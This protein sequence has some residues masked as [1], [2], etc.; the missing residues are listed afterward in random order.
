V[1]RF[2]LLVVSNSKKFTDNFLINFAK[3][4]NMKIRIAVTFL[5]IGL[6]VG[7]FAQWGRIHHN[8]ERN[9]RKHFEKEGEAIGEKHAT[10]AANE[11]IESANDGIDKWEE[12]EEEQFADEKVFIDTNFIEYTDIQWQRL[13]FVSGKNVVF[14][15]KPFNYEKDEKEPSNWFLKNKSKGEVQ[16]SSLD[17][18]KVIIVSADGYL[19]PKIENA[20]KDYLP[21]NFTLEFDFMMPVIPFSKPF[22][23]YFY[24]KDKQKS[25]GSAPIKINQNVVTFKDSTGYYPVMANDENGMSNWYHLSVSYNKGFLKIYLNERLMVTYNEEINPTGITIDYYAIAPIFYKNLL[26]ASDQEP[27]IDQINSGVFTSYDIDYIAYKNRLSGI[28]GSIL[29]K[30]ANLLKD[31]PDLKLDIDVYFSQFEDKSDNKK[32][33]E[34]KTTAIAKTLLAMGV[35]VT[36]INMNFKGSVEQKPGSED[37]LKSEAVYFKKSS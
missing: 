30:V 8:I 11:G 27:I 26:I 37:N 7:S 36:Q 13:R 16:V 14:Y 10:D 2:L 23:I 12:W 3:I 24:A 28:G 15:D 6:S 35:N 1:V 18:G 29:A 34:A 4:L 17:Q 19:T 31:N 20:E 32:Y 33:G 21:D 5:L 22:Y 9:T 25:N